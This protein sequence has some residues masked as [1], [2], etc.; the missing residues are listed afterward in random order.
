MEIER[1][2][3]GNAM[4]RKDGSTGVIYAKPGYYHWVSY[5]WDWLVAM[6]DTATRDEAEAAIVAHWDREE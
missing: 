5:N 1:D 4:H 6:G 2:K 3:S